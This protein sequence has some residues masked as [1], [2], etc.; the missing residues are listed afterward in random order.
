LRRRTKTKKEDFVRSGKNKDRQFGLGKN[1]DRQFKI[2]P[3]DMAGW[4]C[5]EASVT[6]CVDAFEDKKMDMRAWLEEKLTPQ[7]A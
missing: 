7:Q 5:K 6:T 2:S 1:K 4:K 3:S